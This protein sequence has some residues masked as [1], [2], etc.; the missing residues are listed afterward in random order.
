VSRRQRIWLGLLAWVLCAAV[1]GYLSHVRHTPVF[2]MVYWP[3]SAVVVVFAT[4]TGGTRGYRFEMMGPGVVRSASGFEVHISD[5]QLEYREGDHVISWGV[6][7]SQGGGGT[8]SKFTLSKEGIGAWDEPFA[9]EPIGGKKKEEIAR[10][11][12]S[13]LMY[14]Q[15]RGES[16][17]GFRGLAG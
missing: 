8:V 13:A 1:C 12:L 14:R 17:V 11:V 9:A 10:A 7:A 5:S 3:L 15:L 16:G 4:R 6:A 2:L